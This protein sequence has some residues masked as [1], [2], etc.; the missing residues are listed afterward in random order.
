LSLTSS[1]LSSSGGTRAS[2]PESRPPVRFNQAQ[3]L[4][5]DTPHRALLILIAFVIAAG[6]LLLQGGTLPGL[7]KAL[8]LTGTDP[9]EAEAER[10]QLLTTI[11]RAGAAVLEYSALRRPTG[12]LYDPALLRMVHG[13]IL[14]A[15]DQRRREKLQETKEQQIELRLA[16]IDVQR[17]A[18]LE[19]RRSGAY[20]SSTL[21]EVCAAMD[22]EQI[23]TELK[24]GLPAQTDPASE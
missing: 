1:R 15:S 2:D 10:A 4:P 23:A 7:V 17:R 20:A 11:N 22:A 18:L 6:T 5:D 9:E 13:R 24:G 3:T 14:Q 8:R 19:A 21:R 16:V 12:G